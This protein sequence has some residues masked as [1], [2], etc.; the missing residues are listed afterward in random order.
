MVVNGNKHSVLVTGA[1]GLI[2]RALLHELI[3]RNTYDVRAQVRSSANARAQIGSSVDLTKVWIQEGDFTRVG[4][5]EVNNLT[6]DCKIVVHLAGLVHQPDAP[7]QEYE[8]ANVRATQLMADAAIQNGVDTFVFLSTAAV[9]GPGPFE[10]VQETTAPAAK[11]P[12]AVSKLTSEA[13]LQKLAGQIPRIIILR[14][15][16]VFG[17][18]D[19]GNLLS[20]IKE[21]KNQRYRHIGA[22]A[23][24]KSVIYS[25][26][27]AGAIALCLDRLP[28]GVHVM[29]VANPEPVSMKDLT[30]EIARALNMSGKIQSVPA[31]LLKMGLKAAAVLMPGKL[32]TE[33]QLE[34]LTTTTT[35][36]VSKLVQATGFAP[37]ST[38]ASALKAE[39]AWATAEQLL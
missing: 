19:R 31:P 18:G 26:D 34:K 35:C 2:G 29:N 3:S 39:I 21:I 30:E 14:P 23:T 37:R 28:H 9:Y 4:E 8:V 7:Y 27:L 12:Y 36:S 33:E 15:S 24:G 25:R 6:R 38:L 22:G 1:N 5:R 16:M 13:Y 20:L 17:E 10:A 11:T 32:P